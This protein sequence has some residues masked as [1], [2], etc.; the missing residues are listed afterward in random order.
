[1]LEMRN[2]SK[3]FGT[4]RAFSGVEVTISPGEVHALMGENG[5]GKSMQMKILAGAVAADPVGE[6]RIA[7]QDV[8]IENPIGAKALG[9]AIIYQEWSLAPNLTVAENIYL[10]CEPHR[11]IAIDRRAMI[12]GCAEILDG[13]GAY[14]GPTTNVSDLSI[15]EC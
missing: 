14:F 7:R 9:I 8:T 5:A 1:M 12:V 13:L 11:G 2:I 4:V 3:T 15:G 6:F 10:G